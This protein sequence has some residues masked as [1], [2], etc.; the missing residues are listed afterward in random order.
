M[1]IATRT[2]L[3]IVMVISG[4]VWDNVDA[5]Q[6]SMDTDENLLL[7]I[8][9]LKFCKNVNQIVSKNEKDDKFDD[10]KCNVFSL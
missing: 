9:H 1:L 10:G 3:L 7:K 2:L 8:C 6:L 5:K 4:G